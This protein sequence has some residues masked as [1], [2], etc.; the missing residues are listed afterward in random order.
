MSR[1]LS[2]TM[3]IPTYE[4]PDLLSKVL[5]YHNDF[6]GTIIVA[7]GSALPSLTGTDGDRVRLLHMPGDL[8]DDGNLTDRLRAAVAMVDTDYIMMHA[9]RRITTANGYRAAVEFLDANPAY[10][11]ADGRY[12]LFSDARHASEDT[13]VYLSEI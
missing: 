2:L 1:T 6:P 10:V 13:K 8:V 11:A 4:R 3:I 5:R 9:D 12:V 7:D